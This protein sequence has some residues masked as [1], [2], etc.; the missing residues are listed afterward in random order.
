MRRRRDPPDCLA[1]Y[2]AALALHNDTVDRFGGIYNPIAPGVTRAWHAVADAWEV[3]EDA[4]LEAGDAEQAEAARGLHTRI[5]AAL[6]A[7]RRVDFIPQTALAA[8]RAELRH[9]RRVE[10]QFGREHPFIEHHLQLAR[11]H[12]EEAGEP[13]RAA[14]IWRLIRMRRRAH[15][16]SYP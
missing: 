3:A 1:V 5:I 12:F 11:R 10:A 15:S 16:G 8:A 13:R 4:C 2:D 9:A 7:V 6:K 14:A